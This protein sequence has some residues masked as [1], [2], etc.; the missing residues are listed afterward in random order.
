MAIESKKTKIDSRTRN[1]FRIRKIV[2][3]TGER[4]RLTVFRSGKH[5][6]AQLV[7]DIDGKTLLAASTAEGEVKQ[8]IEKVASTVKN[9]TE[10]QEGAE[11][12]ENAHAGLHFG[13]SRSTK[14]VIAA[15]AVGTILGQRATAKNITSVVFDRN[16]RVYQGRVKAV[17]E[18]ARAGGL[19]F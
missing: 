1:K 19:N 12:Q 7:S 10:T 17:A 2:S 3:G 18:G 13:S 6:Y 9:S 4:P 14:S 5:T 16:G 8:A 11:S 15:Y